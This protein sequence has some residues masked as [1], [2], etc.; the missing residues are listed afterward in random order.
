MTENGAASRGFFSLFF[1]SFFKFF[2]L[3]GFRLH[4]WRINLCEWHSQ[5][6]TSR[7]LCRRPCPFFPPSLSSS[8]FLSVMQCLASGII[9]RCARAHERGGWRRRGRKRKLKIFSCVSVP[10]YGWFSPAVLSCSSWC[11]WGRACDSSYSL[12]Q[13]TGKMCLYMNPCEKIYRR[14]RNIK[15][16]NKK[17]IMRVRVCVC[18]WDFRYRDNWKIF[19]RL[20]ESKRAKLF[21]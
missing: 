3:R 2:R 10:R 15:L 20:Y 21:L 11:H 5:R 1:F 8:L 16:W 19:A 17:F 12:K 14:S 13:I 9:S 18:R 4:A 7:L 6:R